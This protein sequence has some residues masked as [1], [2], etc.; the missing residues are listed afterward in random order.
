MR[1]NSIRGALGDVWRWTGTLTRHVQPST[2]A[3]RFP[4]DAQC[5]FS[6]IA[7]RFGASAQGARGKQVSLLGRPPAS[8]NSSRGSARASRISRALQ[9]W[10][11]ACPC[12]PY[13]PARVCIAPRP[14]DSLVAGSFAD[15]EAMRATHST[16]KASQMADKEV[17]SF[18]FSNVATTNQVVR[19]SSLFGTPR[20]RT[21]IGAKPDSL[22]P[23]PQKAQWQRKNERCWKI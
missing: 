13:D 5:S 3:H 22:E 4:R 8:G 9:C 7:R 10:E 23:F 12:G 19:R 21:T 6:G 11:H 20:G 14:L 1:A 15:V 2:R 18:F 16:W 17:G